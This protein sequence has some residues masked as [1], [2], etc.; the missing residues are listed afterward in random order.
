MLLLSTT[1]DQD[2]LGGETI[3][4]DVLPSGDAERMVDR[5]APATFTERVRTFVVDRSDGN[6]FFIEE[7]LRMLAD[8]GITH[9]LPGTLVLPDTVQALLAARI[10]LL[11]PSAKSALQAA[12]VIGRTFSADSVRALVGEEPRLDVLAGR[13]FVWISEGSATFVHALTRD[14]AYSS[15][16]TARR[17]HM[18]AGYATWLEEAGGARD[19]DAAE[20]AHHYSEAVRPEDEDLAWQG[21]EEELARMRPRAIVWLR[22]AAGLAARRYEM[23]EAVA[24][25]E[26]A[27]ALEPDPGMRGE[28][29]QEIAHAN[30]LYFDGKAFAAA[31][32]EAIALAERTIESSPISTRSSRS[33]PWPGPACGARLHHPTSCRAGSTA[34]WS[35]QRPIARP[36]R[37]R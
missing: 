18:H 12:A 21:E 6:P 28:L 14:V 33:R 23:R 13:G 35:G 30:A 19:E 7:L 3:G 15:L 31:M 17:V 24:L 11:P 34:R 37:R 5:L 10:D 22:R 16:T 27:V 9:E 32:E 25:L 4:L 36:A 29:W 2:A 1:R 20:L 26:R 8:Q